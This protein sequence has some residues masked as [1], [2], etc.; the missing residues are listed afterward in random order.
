MGKNFRLLVA[1]RFLYTFAVQMQAIV[2]GWRMYELTHDALYLGLIGLVEAVPAIGLALVAGYIV[3]HG[4]PLVIYRGVVLVSFLSGLIMFLSQVS[5]L[6]LDIQRQIL[7]LFMSSFLTGLARSFSQ[8]AMYATVPKLVPR[9]QLAQSSAWMSSAM[10]IARISGPAIGGLVFGWAGIIASSSCVCAFLV[11]ASILLQF[12][13]LHE[14]PRTARNSTRRI[15]DELLSG[16]RFVWYHP[17]LLPAL[18]LDMVSVLFGGVTALLPIYAADILRVGPKGLGLLRASP[19]IGATVTSLGLT[20][21]DI[22]ARAGRWLFFAVAG[23][24]LCILTFAVS[25]NFVVS[26]VALGLSGAFDSV[27]MVVRSTAVQMA[28]PQEM[29]GRISAVNSIFIGSSNEL[30]ELESGLAA[31]VFGTV[32]A[33]VFGALICLAT[34][35]FVAWR[36]PTLRKMNL[37]DLEVDPDPA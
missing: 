2:I 23:F 30:G 25:A 19:A 32:P 11:F 8:P 21:F 26:L 9:N 7:A 12:V 33:A 17:I 35:S 3:D 4:R 24:G 18:S 15:R 6:N 13:S 29:R 37:H 22:R 5:H 20:R 34:V 36:A 28:S 14:S 1:A 31:Q 10:Q 27:S 16:A